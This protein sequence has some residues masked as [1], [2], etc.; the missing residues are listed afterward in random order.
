[1]QIVSVTT[2]IDRA[3]PAGA[4]QIAV[5][6][7]RIQSPS[8]APPALCSLL[9]AGMPQEYHRIATSYALAK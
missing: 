2:L 9:A 6:H 1:M 5:V 3:Q 7:E 8:H 4:I